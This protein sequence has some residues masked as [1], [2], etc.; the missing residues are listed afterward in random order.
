MAGV[1]IHATLT[2]DGF[3]AGAHGEVD[4][5]FD[6]PSAPEDQ[7]VVDRV[8]ANIGAVVGGANKAQTI[9]EG[10]IPYGGLVK[11]P[12]YL[13]THTPADPI[14]R[15]GVT[16]TFVVDDIAAAVEEA[17]RAAGDKWVSLLGGK[18]ARQCLRLDLV[19]EIH[20]DVVPVLL[21]GGISLFGGLGLR[22]D[23]ER[24]ETSAYASETHLRFRV[25]RLPA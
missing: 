25:A 3:L 21:G 10:E 12:V 8:C 13:M 17:K 5:M 22:V 2:L 7:E 23:L 11:A 14:E 20:L 1:F 15:E 24:L 19:D 16:Y 18:V 9:E 6:F 4:W